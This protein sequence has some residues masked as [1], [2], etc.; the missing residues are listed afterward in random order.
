MSS[1]PDPHARGRGEAVGRE[2][3]WREGERGRER[4]RKG[5]RGTRGRM[6]ERLGQARLL[7]PQSPLQCHTSSHKATPPPTRPHLFPQGHTS[8][9]EATPPN[10]LPSSIGTRYSIHEPMGIIVITD[11]SELNKLSGSRCRRAFWPHLFIL[12]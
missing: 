2:G 1:D 9:H 4:K 7:K 3:A 12:K 5:G 6:R 11:C 8:S 10:P